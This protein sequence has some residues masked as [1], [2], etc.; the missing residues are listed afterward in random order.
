MKPFCW[1]RKWPSV[2]SVDHDSLSKIGSAARPHALCIGDMMRRLNHMAILLLLL[3]CQLGRVANAESASEWVRGQF[4]DSRLVALE[5]T[6]SPGADKVYLGWQISMPDDWKTYWRS[7]GDAGRPP[8]ITV[9]ESENI[10]DVELLFPVPSRFEIFNILTIGYKDEAM[11]PLVLSLTNPGEA[12]SLTLEVD[13][14]VCKDICVPLKA[15]HSIRLEKAEFAD[16]RTEF[17]EMLLEQL[18]KVPLSMDDERARIHVKSV[19]VTGPPGFQNLIVKLGSDAHLSGAEIFVEGEAGFQFDLPRKTILSDG[20]NAT[21]VIPVGGWEE[22]LDIRNT[23][24]TLTILDGWGGAVEGRFEL[25][26][27]N[28]D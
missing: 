22:G 21:F 12:V 9:L 1:Q 3:S 14:M 2:Q 28:T 11:L 5:Q 18:A 19:E 27:S 24:V 8:R 20:S 25:R 6:V 15:V 10:E 7:P 13:F 16:E 23:A 4:S 17:A 26:G